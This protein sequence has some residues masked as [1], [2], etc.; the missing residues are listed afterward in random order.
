MNC[1]NIDTKIILPVL[2]QIEVPYANENWKY[3]SCR[4]IHKVQILL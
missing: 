3:E 2:L 1:H 4:G